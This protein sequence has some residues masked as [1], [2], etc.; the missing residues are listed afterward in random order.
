MSSRNSRTRYSS[1]IW[2]LTLAHRKKPGGLLTAVGQWAPD[3]WNLEAQLEQVQPARLDARA[4]RMQLE[5][6][7][8]LAGGDAAAGPAGTIEVNAQLNG[9]LNEGQPRPVNLELDA[10][11][12][13]QLVDLRTFN[14][15]AGDARASASGLATQSA[16]AKRWSIK[17][18]AMLAQFN[19]AVWWPGDGRIALAPQQE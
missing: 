12:N 1:N 8:K 5:G 4:P 7:V 16:D 19:P 11:I 17:G 3:R 9:D 18:Q 2:R 13:P 14:A 15:T 10:G 6:P